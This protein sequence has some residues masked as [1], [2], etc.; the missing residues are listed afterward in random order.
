MLP[1]ENLHS[2]QVKFR[3]KFKKFIKNSPKSK[4]GLKMAK[5]G[6]FRP[7]SCQANSFPT[8]FRYLQKKKNWPHFFLQKWAKKRFFRFPI[9]DNYGQLWPNYDHEVIFF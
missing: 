5:N 1:G 3:K 6:Y 7:K 4:I 9:I 2:L 8:I